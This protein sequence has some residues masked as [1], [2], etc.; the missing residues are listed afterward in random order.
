MKQ[1]LLPA[2]WLVVAFVIIVMTILSA[3]ALFSDRRASN[4]S[5]EN[6]HHLTAQDIEVFI[7]GAVELAGAFTFKKGATLQE[8]LSLAKPL[9]QADLKK[10]KIKSKLRNGQRIQ[11]P[12][13]K[14]ITVILDGAVEQPG[15]YK[16]PKGSRWE[17]LH[18][19]ISLH[20]K[21]DLSSLKKRKLLKDQDIV[22]VKFKDKRHQGRK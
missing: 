19:L 1:K 20:P 12:V 6:P 10:L 22:Y 17:D 16:I 5:L 7:D 2:E 13:K 8:L 14:M 21:A 9:P 3:V 11:V 18:Q 15:P 4:L